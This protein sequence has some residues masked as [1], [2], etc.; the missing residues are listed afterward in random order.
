MDSDVTE[1]DDYFQSRSV[2]PTSQNQS[3]HDWMESR[4]RTLW[5]KNLYN[6]D[7]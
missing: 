1:G 3:D 2:H 7:G 6:E 5:L 4:V